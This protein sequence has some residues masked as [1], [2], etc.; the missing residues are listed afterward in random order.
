MEMYTVA[1]LVKDTVHQ[2]PKKFTEIV[3]RAELIANLNSD[4][5]IVVEEFPNSMEGYP[6]S[7]YSW[8]DGGGQSFNVWVSPVDETVLVT[9][10]ETDSVFNFFGEP[11]SVSTYSRQEK[12]YD[13]LP[14]HLI[15]GVKNQSEDYGLLNIVNPESNNSLYH[16]SGAMM[17]NGKEWV[18]SPGWLK[19]TGYLENGNEDVDD[20]GVKYCS[21]LFRFEYEKTDG[22]KSVNKFASFKKEKLKQDDSAQYVDAFENYEASK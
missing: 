11:E 1:Q 18:I 16:A 4:S 14:A 8:S 12:F 6:L 19:Q 22:E 13:F 5:P 9:V 15:A 7:F 10:Y 21:S 17:F 2:F 20:G 3:A